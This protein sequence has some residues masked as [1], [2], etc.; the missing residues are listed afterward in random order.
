M[1]NFEMVLSVGLAVLVIRCPDVRM[2][3][4]SFVII[5]IFFGTFFGASIDKNL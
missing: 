4:V 1:T 2:N 3:W 5:I